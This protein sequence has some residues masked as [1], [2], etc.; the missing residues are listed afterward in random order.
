MWTDD[1]V[2]FQVKYKPRNCKQWVSLYVYTRV[3]LYYLRKF[4]A[5]VR[6]VSSFDDWHGLHTWAKVGEVP[7][8]QASDTNTDIPIVSTDLFNGFQYLKNRFIAVSDYMKPM[9]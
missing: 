8:F 1:I 9:S 6:N 2:F 3:S 4:N 7:T 5:A